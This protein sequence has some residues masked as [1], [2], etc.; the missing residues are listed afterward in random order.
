MNILLKWAWP[1][2][3]FG[4]LFAAITPYILFFSLPAGAGLIPWLAMLLRSLLGHLPGIGI[5]GALFVLAARVYGYT[6]TARLVAVSLGMGAI[7]NVILT[8]QIIIYLLR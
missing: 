3:T 4:M 1:F 2:L 6:I 7:V 8:Y 5:V